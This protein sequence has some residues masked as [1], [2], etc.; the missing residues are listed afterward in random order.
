MYRAYLK[1]FA[2][3][4]SD[5]KSQGQRG[6]ADELCPDQKVYTGQYRNQYYGFSI[7]IPAG[8]KGYWNSPRCAKA[9]EG[10]VCMTDHG[11]IIPLAGDAQIEAYTGHQMEP[12]WSVSDY[13]KDEIA[14][15]KKREGVRQVK[16]LSSKGVRLGSLRAR[17][18]VVQFGEKGKQIISDR[19]VALH[20]GVKYDLIL[21]TLVNRYEKDRRQF[22]QVIASWRL[23][24]RIE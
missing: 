14:S 16:V 11:R 2:S 19:V 10:C 20:R 5:G 12:E 3:L 18:F 7:V 13:E 9:E 8:L 6:K 23:I 4:A 22:E 15:L 24:P 21:H 17:R 1:A